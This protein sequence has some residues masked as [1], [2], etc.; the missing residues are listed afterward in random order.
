MLKL[1][2][3]LSLVT[4]LA[5][6]A[7]VCQGTL[8]LA[9]TTGQLSGTVVDAASKQPIAGVKV[10][11]ASPSQTASA[12][13]DTSGHFSL[14][15]LAPDTY[16]V[17]A[18]V[19]GY[20]PLSISGET[21]VADN[22]T[23]VQ[24]TAQKE[25]QTI[26]RVTARSA[27][28]LV[29]PGTTADVYSINA[30]AQ[31]K[32]AAAGGGGNQDS[33]FSALA[34]VPGVVVAPG[35][36]GYIGA[37]AGLSIRGGDYDQI[38]YQID[39]VPV[40]R[41]FDN[42]P[43]GATSS[44]GQQELQV[45]TGAPPASATSEGISGYINQVI[46]TGTL[47]AF[48]SVN[49]GLGGPAFYHKIA[50]EAGGESANRRFSYYG[51]LG[52]YN[53]DFR[54]VDQ[55]NGAG[56]SRTYGVSYGLPC[57]PTVSAA[58]T[59][60]CY[61]GST[62][63]NGQIQGPGYLFAPSA[64][65]VDRDSIANL[66]Y[67]FPH[68]DGSRDDLQGLYMVNALQTQVYGSINDQGGVGFL[69]AIGAGTPTY[70]DGYN[71]RL[72]TGGFLPANYRQYAS[73]YAFPNTPAHAFQGAIGPD[74]RDGFLNNQAIAKLQFTKSLGSSAYFRVY[75]YTY[76]SNWLNQGPVSNNFNG[77]LGIPG[78]Y[79]LSAHTRGVS[80]QFAD[81]IN[82]KNLLQLGGDFTKSTVLRSNNTQYLDSSSRVS[83]RTAIG[84]LVDSSNPTNGICYSPTGV[85][86]QCYGSPSTLNMCYT[87]GL[88]TPC[89]SALNNG[90]GLVAP[91]W[92]TI[93]QAYNGTVAP[94][95]AA[96]CGAGACQ[97]LVVGNGKYATF[98]QVKPIFYGASLTDEF[99]PN[100]KLT[101]NGGLRLDV[102]Q[103]QGADTSGGNA[104]AFWYS[105]YNREMCLNNTTQL[106]VT[107][108]KNGLLPSDSCSAAPGLSATNFTNP[109]GV[110][111]QTYPV[112][113]PR[114][115]FTY[116][117][118][119]N[120]VFR[121]S[122]G[123]YAQP[124][125]SAFEQYD[126]LQTNAPAQ[127]YGVYGFQQYGYTTPNHP[128]PPAAS[129]NYDFSIEHQFPQQLSLKLTP[130]L[131]KT[132]NQIEQFY[133][134]R[135]T[136]FVSGLNVGNQTSEGVELEV[137]KGDFARPGLAA[138]LSFAY[139]H[140][141]VNYNTLSNGTTV[142]TPV[143]NA[144]NAYNALT[145][146]GGGAPC[147]T[148][149]TATGGGTADPGCA[150]GSI[151]NPYYNAPQQSLN[152]FSTGTATI[153]YDTIPAGVGVS[154]V[155]IGYPYVASLI[156]NEHVKR[157]SIT[158][159]V[160]FFAGQ[161]YSSPLATAGIDPTTCS[162]TLGKGTAG[163]PRYGFG[164]QPG[165]AFDAASCGQLDSIPNLQTGTFDG[166][167]AYVQ[168][169]QLLMHMQL[170]YDVTKN[171]Q[172]VANV[173]NILN[174]CFGGTNVPWKVQGACGYGLVNQGLNGGVGNTYNPGDAI[175]PVSQYSY[176]PF[177]NQQP[178]GIYV[179]A[180]F[181]I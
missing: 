70:A 58:V 36:S 109:S 64:N 150:A 149:T 86:T 131:R 89:P 172:L 158:P 47:P 99:R 27:T 111:T 67:Y 122:Y 128:I 50:F 108:A 101:I 57:D 170:S 6:L 143:I 132:Q 125:N 117:I 94:I 55:Y 32:L 126:F 95:T 72:P 166:I 59:P 180:N 142:L 169:S 118:D 69:N 81:Q 22:T 30:V 119:P 167:G 138:K 155:G 66:H 1:R 146:A 48:S 46:K 91:Q 25:L 147:Y 10:S 161:R 39:G 114:L 62:F 16:V 124:P 68:K 54:Y 171:F 78:D 133:L 112:F 123:R 15:G 127:L 43:S 14:L 159:I 82:S 31:Q 83:T 154:S 151:A 26:G 165:Q 144:V 20:Q 40:N 51:G 88:P 156:L 134:N 34:T 80:F 106:V 164:A 17:S 141:Y 178:L 73:Q 97:Y 19:P 2:F 29:K 49:I 63:N 37:G 38:G 93:K 174:T 107:K 61:N 8:V 148:V 75:G 121:G 145:K 168:P 135:A 136:N 176:A 42:Y 74:V 139:T 129:N 100:S 35:Q 96:G 160:Q 175:Q 41:A 177:W 137:D 76:Y 105:A 103:Y 7:M 56:V 120:T 104:R 45:Y 153:P 162:A 33:A 24:L 79:E 181:K 98:N 110:S 53:Q 60:S 102:Y 130:F 23:V 90:A 65:V 21:V 163:D 5:I 179:N 11:A 13:T 28:S 115:G 4:I 116:A 9:G 44:L 140:S 71:L 77:N 12:T 87:K 173:S 157:L 92:A 18:Q 3:G 52:G 84:V 113:Q 152:A 85:P